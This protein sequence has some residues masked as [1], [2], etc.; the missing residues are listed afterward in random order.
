[1]GDVAE[2]PESLDDEHASYRLVP[3]HDT[4]WQQRDEVEPGRAFD[5]PFDYRGCTL[6]YSL[7]GDDWGE[8]KA[9]TS[10]GYNQETGGNLSRGD[11]FLDPARALAFHATF[12]DELLTRYVHNPYLVDLS[13]L[14][15]P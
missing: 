14:E 13:P 11:W 6:P 3:I 7:D 4:L 5:N 10:W 12:K 15:E 8:D 2:T 9:N 1:M